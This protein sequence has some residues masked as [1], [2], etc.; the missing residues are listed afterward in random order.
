MIDE[1]K[2]KPF[3]N[4]DEIETRIRRGDHQAARNDLRRIGPREIS[5][6]NVTRFAGLLRRVD[7]IQKAVRLL[8]P[9]VRD[10]QTLTH[11]TDMEWMEYACLL[12]RLGAIHEAREILSKVDS[13][14]F[15]EALLYFTFT[16][17]PEWRY[18]ETIGPLETYI[19]MAPDRP[20]QQLIVKV[21]LIAA[22]LF[23]G[24]LIEAKPLIERARLEAEKGEYWFLLG[25]I[26]ELAAQWAIATDQFVIAEQSLEHA[27]RL[28][29]KTGTTESLYAEKWRIVLQFLRAATPDRE[30]EKLLALRLSA[31]RTENWET[32]RDCDFHSLQRLPQQK[33]FDHLYSGSPYQPFRDR[34]LRVMPGLKPSSQN[35]KWQLSGSAG[36]SHREIHVDSGCIGGRNSFLR[37]AITISSS[38]TTKPTPKR[39]MDTTAR[40][41]PRR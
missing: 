41:T 33:L 21:N 1:M 39:A 18:A 23:C 30:H 6:Q 14:R 9:I 31:L 38:R 5:R 37:P 28:L 35:Y 34:M 15:P 12:V 26:H 3:P 19:S 40:N 4:L 10:P 11:A 2:I 16:L 8:N 7:L 32:V 27:T 20:Y 22:Y 17:T 24:R 36:A 25:S 29:Q 13:Q